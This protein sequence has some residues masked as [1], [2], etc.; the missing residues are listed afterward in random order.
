MTARLLES[1]RQ[2]MSAVVSAY[3]GNREC[4]AARLGMP[5]KR[6]DNHIYQNAGSSP[7]SDEQLHLLEQDAGTSFLPEYICGLYGGVFV[8]LPEVAD[9]DNLDLYTRAVQ[10]SAKRGAVDQIIAKAL[11]DGVIEPG[12]AAAIKA[13]HR[14]YMSA[15][16][17]EVLA[18]LILHT[19]EPGAI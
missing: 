17:S 8:P 3:P 2:V 18:T 14:R 15:R 6:F 16:H 13:A 19:N 7:L 11:E 5:L 1:R 9:L 4:A 10:A 12:E